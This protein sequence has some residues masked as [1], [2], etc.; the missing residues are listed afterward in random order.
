MHGQEETTAVIEHGKS[1]AQ[2]EDTKPDGFQEVQYLPTDEDM[3]KPSTSEIHVKYM[4]VN[5]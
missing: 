2:C 5:I 1:E 4:W 3:T